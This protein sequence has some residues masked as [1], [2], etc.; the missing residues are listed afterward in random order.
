[1]KL[2]REEAVGIWRVPL[3]APFAV[4]VTFLILGLPA[5]GEQAT[6]LSDDQAREV[7]GAAI[8]SVYP[9]PC[10][11]TYRNE[12]LES[13]T[14]SVRKD[15]LLDGHLDNSVYF[16]RVASDA[17]DYVVE[18]DGKPLLMSQVS[19]DCCGYGVVAV[20]RKTG[21][22]YWFAGNRNPEEL[23]KQFVGNEGLHPDSGRPTLFFSLYRELVWGAASDS[24]LASLEQLRDVIQ[25]NFQPAYSPYER[26]NVWRRKFRRWWKHLQSHISQLKLETTYE[27]TS[28]GTLVRGY[29]FA[30]FELTVPRRDPPPRGTP[31]LF[32]WT[33]L[34]RSD[35][36]VERLPSKVIYAGR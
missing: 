29:A 3:K 30:G 5:A 21:R 7:A 1:M 12:N 20:D 6:W 9:Q 31:Q 35:G 26:D 27:S 8:H 17:C 16:Y 36:T 32:Q 4:L 24:E 2:G 14:L 22:S 33:L 23:F 18:K 34:I 28:E 13:F 10:Y 11:S 25:R 19:M 15:P